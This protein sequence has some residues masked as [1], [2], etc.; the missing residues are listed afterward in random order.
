MEPEIKIYDNAAGVTKAFAKHLAQWIEE[1]KTPLFHIALSG[2]NTPKL[3]FRYL[4]DN[5]KNSI[6]WSKVHFWWGD[7]RM[8]PPDDDESNYKM[9]NE[10][11]LSQIDI[12]EGNIHRI[13][14]EEDPPTESVRYG[15]EIESLV[16]DKETWPA[17]DL[18]ILGMGDDG[19]TASIFPNQ[20]ELLHS[21]DVCEVATHP[22]SG[23]KRITLTGKVLNSAK[24]TAFLVT[25]ENK[26]K[27]LQEIFSGPNKG[28][29]LPAF[30]IHPA[31]ELFWFVD[32]AAAG[33]LEKE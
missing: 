29:L 9:T 16:P 8:V 20:M 15:D 23:Q 3:L 27:R 12:P 24:K 7:E 11:L 31:G 17:F 6:E 25:G 30:H 32:Q 18:I 5:Y 4:A 2:G 28:R 21:L 26:A 19:H 33:K 1:S 14:G 13:R 10:L 22:S